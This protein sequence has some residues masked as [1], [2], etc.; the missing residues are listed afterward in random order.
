MKV[1]SRIPTTPLSTTATPAAP[2][3]ASAPVGAAG[4]F[5]ASSS[6]P[7]K[8]SRL[9]LLSTG[10]LL[11]AGIVT[12]LGCDE[13][14][15]SASSAPAASAEENKGAENAKLAA[16]L[17]A[18]ASAAPSAQKAANGPPENGIFAKGVAQTQA[19]RGAPANVEVGSDGAEP[20]ITWKTTD[21]RWKANG[22][23]SVGIRISQNSAL[24]TVE[25]GV[26]FSAPKTEGAEGPAAF[27]A[28]LKKSAPSAQQ[29]GQLPEGAK[30]EIGLLKGSEIRF[31]RDG[32]GIG[33]AVVKLAKGAN[34]EVARVV[35]AAGESLLFLTVPAP[36]KPVGVGAF[37]IAGSRETIGGIDTVLYRLYRLKELT[38]DKATLS[39]E[40][41]G[42][43]A[44]PD[45]S[46]PGAPK[47]LVLSQYQCEG[48]ADL[49]IVPGDAL[50][51]SGKSTLK[52]G[53]LFRP[54]G[55]PQGRGGTSQSITES[56]FARAK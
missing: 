33:N 14:K 6:S 45:A 26:A 44:D 11:G 47:G 52:Q 34:E 9:A 2:A 27:L 10:L 22:T 16:A 13:K 50:A 30:K 21:E 56:S 18:A 35:E 19:R 43:A 55:N 36:P 15:T 12:G 31:E 49:E 20:R 40:S 53:L 25:F 54:E 23:L 3:A 28:E 5:G 7:A 24:P 41:H 32:T 38:K 8:R 48:T 37:W 17:K 29:L 39:I 42:Y 1:A 4:V 51:L 46:V